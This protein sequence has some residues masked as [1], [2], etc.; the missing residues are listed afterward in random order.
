MRG[1]SA[2]R[3]GG[4]RSE[5]FGHGHVRRNGVAI[6]PRESRVINFMIVILRTTA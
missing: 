1:V 5:P 4:D 2:L 6:A 3:F